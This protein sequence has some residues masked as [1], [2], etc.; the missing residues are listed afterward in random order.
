MPTGLM[1]EWIQSEMRFWR[2]K[3]NNVPGFSKSLK[4]NIQAEIHLLN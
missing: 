4:S 2:C 1:N 3:I